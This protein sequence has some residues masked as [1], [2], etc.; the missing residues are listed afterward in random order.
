MKMEREVKRRQ[1][2]LAGTRTGLVRPQVSGGAAEPLGTLR[3]IA[4]CLSLSPH[5]VALVTLSHLKH[6]CHHKCQNLLTLDTILI[7]L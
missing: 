5:V 4:A 7:M 1:S 6:A 3:N 2:V